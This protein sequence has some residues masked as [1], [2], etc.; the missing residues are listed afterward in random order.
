MNNKKDHFRNKDYKY[1]RTHH[2]RKTSR[3]ATNE[4]IFHLMLISSD[5]YISFLRPEPK[6]K[7]LPFSETAK[8]LLK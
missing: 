2:S 7:R 6:I 4:D 3:L 5:P 1:Y 8:A